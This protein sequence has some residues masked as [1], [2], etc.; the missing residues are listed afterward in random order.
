MCSPVIEF[1]NSIFCCLL[2]SEIGDDRTR[3][4]DEAIR[5]AAEAAEKGDVTM[6]NRIFGFGQVHCV[7]VCF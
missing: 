5:E 1:A 3:V 6:A 7:I 2:L 4:F